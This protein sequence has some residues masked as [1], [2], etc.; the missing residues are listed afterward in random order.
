MLEDAIG[1]KIDITMYKAK[2]IVLIL[3]V[4]EDAI[5]DGHHGYIVYESYKS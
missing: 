4:L 3:V 1:V 2:L 5:G